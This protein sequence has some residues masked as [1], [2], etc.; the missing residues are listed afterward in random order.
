MRVGFNDFLSSQSDRIKVTWNKN[1][2]NFVNATKL[3][4]KISKADAHE[5]KYVTDLGKE[6]ATVYLSR[7]I[8]SKMADFT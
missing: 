1:K 5:L 2:I 8:L 3:V 4:K 6:D 7:A